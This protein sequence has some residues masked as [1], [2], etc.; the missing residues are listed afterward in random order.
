MESQTISRINPRLVSLLQRVVL[1]DKFT[2][3]FCETLWSDLTH[4]YAQSH[5]RYHTLDHII[6]CLDNLDTCRHL[7][8][9]ADDVELAVWYHDVI[10][11]PIRKDN[12]ERS[13]QHFRALCDGYL[14]GS[15]LDNVGRLVLVTDHRSRP[16]SPDEKFIC[17]ID[18]ASL[19]IDWE[20][21]YKD[22]VDL[23]HEEPQTEPTTYVAN[24]LRFF[25]RLFTHDHIFHTD[26]FRERYE[27]QARANI[28]RFVNLMKHTDAKTLLGIGNVNA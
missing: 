17:D 13:S 25:D 10:H 4:K 14:S 28:E 20:G 18:I 5:R 26:Y 6:F 1:K 9:E 24:K 3:A 19:G 21:F 16:H 23:Y 15:T 11:Y 27:V 2:D 7:L 22:S 12:E 8:A